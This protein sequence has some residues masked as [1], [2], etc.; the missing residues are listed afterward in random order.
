MAEQDL[1]RREGLPWRS[2]ELPDSSPV[3]S[4][5]GHSFRILDE[6]SQQL[7]KGLD[8]LKLTLDCKVA[9]SDFCLRCCLT[10][11]TFCACCEDREVGRLF[12]P[13]RVG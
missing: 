10:G 12:T 2:L 3:V 11:F 1:Y 7:A 5:I 4:A 6:Y 13:L 8:E 9:S